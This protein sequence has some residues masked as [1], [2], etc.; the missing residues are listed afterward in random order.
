MERGE[1][2][3]GVVPVENSTEG[4]VNRSLDLLVE[5]E[6]TIIAQVYLK[7]EHCLFSISPLDE[8]TKVSSK[9]QALA[10]CGEWL[11]RNLPG[12]QLENASSTAEAV[13][14]AKGEPGSAAIAGALAGRL[15]EV[16]CVADGIQDRKDNLTRFL[17]V[18]RKPLERRDDVEYKKCLLYTSPS[19]LDAPLSRMPSY[20]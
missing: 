1:C 16:P 10:Q 7:I 20:A 2:D 14:S 12:A 3:Y 18:G 8:I 6:L 4:A 19:K 17:I 9:D 11:R 15:Y 5:T 13:R